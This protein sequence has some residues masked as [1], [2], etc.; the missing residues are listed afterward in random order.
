MGPIRCASEHFRGSEGAFLCSHVS[1]SEF[2]CPG[3]LIAAGSPRVQE[4]AVEAG[5][6][7]ALGED[8]PHLLPSQFPGLWRFSSSW[9][10]AGWPPPAFSH[11]RKTVS[12]GNLRQTDPRKEGKPA[13]SLSSFSL[14]VG[15]DASQYLVESSQYPCKAGSIVSI[16]IHEETGS[17]AKTPSKS[18]AEKVSVLGVKSSSAGF[19]A[20]FCPQ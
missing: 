5:T 6:L 11:G 3:H 18:Q 9:K 19:A 16:F 4:P 15:L 2:S 17:E 1:S 12:L 14:S 13:C 8:R 7:D 10:R 20:L